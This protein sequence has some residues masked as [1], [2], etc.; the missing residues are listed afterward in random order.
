MTDV[1]V[2]RIDDLEN[3]DGRFF[4]AGKGLG[5]SSFGINVSRLPG[6]WADYPDHDHA[7]QG[8][9]EVYVV[10]EGTATLTAGDESW[11]L[12]P[13]MLARVGAEQKRK[14][15]PGEWGVTLLAIGG[16]PGQAYGPKD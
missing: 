3:Y 13:G 7:E 6:N 14:F 16:I 10:L 5:V 9:E 11:E 1:T 12:E 2:K 15:E 8:Q 4:Y